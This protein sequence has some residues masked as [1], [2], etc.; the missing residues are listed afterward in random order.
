M[1][2]KIPNQQTFCPTYTSL[3]ELE[4]HTFNEW[5]LLRFLTARE[6]ELLSPVNSEVRCQIKKELAERE[7]SVLTKYGLSTYQDKLLA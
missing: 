1:A 5:N 3:D 7:E 2:N 4:A 6:E